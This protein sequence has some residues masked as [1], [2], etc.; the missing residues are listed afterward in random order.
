MKTLWLLFHHLNKD[1]VG[2]YYWKEVFCGNFHISL[3]CGMMESRGGIPVVGTNQLHFLCL[4]FSSTVA[5]TSQFWDKKGFHP[6][7]QT[8]TLAGQLKFWVQILYIPTVIV[9]LGVLFVFACP[10]AFYEPGWVLEAWF[11]FPFIR[12]LGREKNLLQQP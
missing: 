2:F 1:L 4:S 5:Q 9:S 6:T 12:Q 11:F 7:I 8:L 10:S 3:G